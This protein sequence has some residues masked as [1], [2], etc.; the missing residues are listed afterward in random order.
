MTLKSHTIKINLPGGIVSAGDLLDIL[1]A[2]EKA[3]VENVR[4]GNR[5]QVFFSVAEEKL[6]GLKQD[7]IAADIIFELNADVH[8]NIISS[9]AIEDVFYHADWLREGVYKDILDLFDYRP[10]LKI[11]VVDN[12]QTFF[13][14]FTG[15]LNFIAS[16]TSNYWYLYI[17]FPKTNSIYL[18]PSLVYSED[19]ADLSSAIER[20]VFANKEQFYDQLTIDGSQ[21]YSLVSASANF[22]QQPMVEALKLPDFK[23]PY[24]EGFNRYGNK[25][26][27]GIYRRDELFQVAFL[28]DVCKLC[29]KT[30]V[31]QLYTTPWKS[32]IVKGIGLEERDLW[33]L[34]LCKHRI[35]VRHASNELNWQVEDL[36]AYGLDL[37]NY[38]VRKFNEEDVR[39]YRLCFAIKTQPK[40]GLFGSIIIRTQ[41]QD[42][43]QLASGTELFEVLHT[44]EFNPNSKD[45]V[46]YRKDVSRAALSACLIELCNYFYELQSQPALM[47]S[48]V[49]LEE[50]KPGDAEEQ[51]RHVVYQCEHCFTVYDE[52]YGDEFNGIVAGTSFDTLQGY[53]CPTC[54]ASKDNFVLVELQRSTVG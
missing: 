17:R 34:V 4:F 51:V 31:G 49:Y 52:R 41:Q 46:S 22:V 44:R 26:W 53:S 18:W 30:R 10:Q 2:A 45:F 48:A 19:I 14:F 20:T 29:L 39:T 43:Q 11:N 38:L 33:D 35:N 28:K 21:L 42:V 24:Y 8:P 23:L 6:E 13:P 9:Y 50:E 47:A 16:D 12:D 15:N 54:E 25:L 1:Q 40:T 32:L 3:E 36:C 37:K 5:Q 7:L 27:L